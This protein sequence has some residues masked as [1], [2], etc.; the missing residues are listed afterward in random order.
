MTG[1]TRRLHAC[2][3]RSPLRSI[4]NVAGT[5]RRSATD[6]GEDSAPFY[7]GTRVSPHTALPFAVHRLMAGVEQRGENDAY[8]RADRL[9]LSLMSQCAFV[10]PVLCQCGA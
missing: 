10:V 8:L 7:A 4:P 2:L 1:W 3:S 5:A 9:D 6:F